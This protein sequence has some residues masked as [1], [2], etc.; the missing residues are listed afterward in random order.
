[1]KLANPVC[2]QGASLRVLTHAELSRPNPKTSNSWRMPVLRLKPFLV[3]IEGSN[4]SVRWVRLSLVF[5]GGFKLGAWWLGS[6]E[7]LW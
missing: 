1:M 3:L 5:G 7:V 6:V 2:Q 4:L